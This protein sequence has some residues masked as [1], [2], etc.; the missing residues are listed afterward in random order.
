MPYHI[1]ERI[2]D[3]FTSA[4]VV[5]FAP[6]VAQAVQSFGKVYSVLLE[7]RSIIIKN[8]LVTIANRSFVFA[9]ATET[10][11][12]V[13]QTFASVTERMTSLS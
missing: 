2:Q 3:G 6:N 12:L 13:Y 1:K 9:F 10:F 4:V 11:G 7:N 5:D 8:P